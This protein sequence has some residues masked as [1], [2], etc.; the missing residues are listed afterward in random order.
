MKKDKYY[1]RQMGKVHEVQGKIQ[2]AHR[3]NQWSINMK[4][5]TPHCHSVSYELKQYYNSIFSH[6]ISRSFKDC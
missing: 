1:K 6:Q 3:K 2:G 4:R 5:F